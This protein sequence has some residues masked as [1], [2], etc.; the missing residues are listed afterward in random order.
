MLSNNNGVNSEFYFQTFKKNSNSEKK[1]SLYVDLTQS[2]R[3]TQHLQHQKP[4][5]WFR[6]LS[7][8]GWVPQYFYSQE[9]TNWLRE[10]CW[11]S[12]TIYFNQDCTRHLVMEWIFNSQIITE[13]RAQVFLVTASHCARN[14]LPVRCHLCPQQF[15]CFT[16]V[17]STTLPRL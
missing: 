15:L 12:R 11:P 4:T 14:E 10:F 13:K 7:F 8:K 17:V 6:N 16:K 5:D 2:L 3:H 9:S 1:M